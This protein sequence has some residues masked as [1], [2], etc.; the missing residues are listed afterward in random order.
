MSTD[1]PLIDLRDVAI[2]F[3][4]SD[5]DVI[6][7]VD[8]FSLGVGAGTL[9]CV[10]GRS[11]SGKT[12]ILN[13]AAALRPPTSGTV[14]W[15]GHNVTELNADLLTL[16]RRSFC[17]F[18]D[19]S[20]SLVPELTALENVLLAAM[21]DRAVRSLRPRAEM[22]LTELGLWQRFGH[23]PHTLSGGERQRVALARALLLEPSVVIIDE[24]TAGLDRAWADSVI[25]MLLEYR[26]TGERAVLA[27]SHDPHLIAAADE[28][29]SPSPAET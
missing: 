29:R 18:V 20:A 19:Q 3:T 7:I 17:G 14:F 13:V 26:K 6:D 1:S 5:G 4:R 28:S 15:N 16:R 21:P 23:R 2:R 8:Q 10:E 9:V 24:P 12:S 25:D 11:G 22:L 27:A